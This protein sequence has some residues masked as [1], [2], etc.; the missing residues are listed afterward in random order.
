MKNQIEIIPGRCMFTYQKMILQDD[1]H[2]RDHAGPEDGPLIQRQMRL[3]TESRCSR[4]PG[5][6]VRASGFGLVSR[7][8]TTVTITQM[9]H[10]HSARYMFSA[11]SLACGESAT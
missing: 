8:T 10:D 4:R 6:P 2:H 1:E 3:P 7:L 11:M 9:I 5:P